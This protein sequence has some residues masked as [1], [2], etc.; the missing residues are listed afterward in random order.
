MVHLTFF[1]PN[2]ISLYELRIDVP[3]TL[4][5]VSKSICNGS[6]KRQ[7][8]LLHRINKLTNCRKFR[9]L[10]IEYE[11]RRIAALRLHDSLMF[12]SQFMHIEGCRLQR[13]S[14]IDF[15]WFFWCEYFSP[16]CFKTCANAMSGRD[17]IMVMMKNVIK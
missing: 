11:Q 12:A 1:I 15:R 17:A 16:G 3:L 5:H 6:C 10:P 9:A 13:S 8:V 14:G 2:P 7:I 4:E